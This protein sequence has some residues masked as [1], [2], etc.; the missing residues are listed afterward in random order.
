MV[1][2]DISQVISRE[3]IWFDENLIV[4]EIVVE[5]DLAWNT[6]FNRRMAW[7]YLIKTL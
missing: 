5:L 7:R 3:P 6:V 1:V 2:N 4:N